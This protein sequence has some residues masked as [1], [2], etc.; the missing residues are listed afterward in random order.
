MQW[1]HILFSKECPCLMFAG[2]DPNG[3]DS[4]NSQW[5]RMSIGCKMLTSRKAGFMHESKYQFPILSH[6]L[7][8]F[9][10][11]IPRTC[12]PLLKMVRVENHVIQN[13]W[14]PK[15][16]AKRPGSEP[17]NMITY[18]FLRHLSCVRHRMSESC[19]PLKQKILTILIA[20]HA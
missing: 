17:L 20:P 15:T 13:Q 3:G 14:H 16:E 6:V 7:E 8:Q 2:D 19:F 9:T 5:D 18:L 10:I 11:P 12:S 4:K 1:C